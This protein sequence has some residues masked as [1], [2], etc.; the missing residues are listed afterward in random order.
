MCPGKPIKPETNPLDDSA[1]DPVEAAAAGEDEEDLGQVL[2]ESSSDDGSGDDEDD[3]VNDDDDGAGELYPREAAQLARILHLQAVEAGLAQ[4]VAE[5]KEGVVNLV[6][7]FS[8]QYH[9]LLL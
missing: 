1:V 9:L 8:N 2:A 7:H 3:D 4:E 5:R 6:S